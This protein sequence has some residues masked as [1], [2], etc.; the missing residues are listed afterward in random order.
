IVHV[1]VRTRVRKERISRCS[2]CH[3]RCTRRHGDGSIL[4]EK[5]AENMTKRRFAFFASILTCALLSALGACLGDGPP[6]ASRSEDGGGG[7]NDGFASDTSTTTQGDTSSSTGDSS[8]PTDAPNDVVGQS[9]AA[10]A[11]ADA[12]ADAGPSLDAGDLPPPRPIAPL[13]T[14]T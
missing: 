12:D 11:S 5:K 3:G 9:D 4:R 7:G 14:A 6:V 8:A 10:D 13:S 1:H 2:V